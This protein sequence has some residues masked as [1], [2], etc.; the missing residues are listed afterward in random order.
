M[1]TR[2]QKEDITKGL[3]STLKAAKVAVFVEFNKLTNKEAIEL[4]RALRAEGAGYKVARKT[5]IA[6]AISEVFPG[7]KDTALPGEIALAT[8][9]DILAAP[10]A[11]YE[12]S[13]THKEQVK[14]V[15]GFFDGIEKT[16]EE[17]IAIAMT[18]SREVSLSKIA[19]LLKSPMQRLAIAV[20]EVAKTK[21]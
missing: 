17:M 9:E 6:R 19:Y 1:I 13:K 3:V 10:R 2:S 7:G 14:I 16:M 8:S 20:S 21:S 15:G 18:P 5:L 12:F 4:R 11:V